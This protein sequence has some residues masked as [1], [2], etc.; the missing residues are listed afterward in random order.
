[1]SE[2]WCPVP[3]FGGRYDISSTGQVRNCKTS[4]VLRPRR[5][6]NGYIGARFGRNSRCYMVHR[7][8]LEAFNRSPEE[9]EQGN[10]KNGVRNDN[11]IENLEWLSCSEN[12]RH[13]YRGLKR[14]QHALT[15]TVLAVGPKNQRRKFCSVLAA[16]KVFK[17]SPGSIASAVLRNHKCKN[18]SFS[19]V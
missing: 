7:L 18:W 8:V 4:H 5:L 9:G 17:V 19:Y 14:K 2:Q 3:G 10:H 1:M 16:S 15:K 6:P 11:R 13:S 12:H